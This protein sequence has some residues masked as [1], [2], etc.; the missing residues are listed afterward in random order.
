MSNSLGRNIIKGEIVI[1]RKDR[2][3]ADLMNGDYRFKCSGGFGMQI[4]TMGTALFGVFMVDGEEARIHSHDI[5]KEATEAYQATYKD[6]PEKA[7][8]L[9]QI[10][11][12]QDTIAKHKL[13]IGRLEKQAHQAGLM[14]ETL[15]AWNEFY[16]SVEQHLPQG[17]FWQKYVQGQKLYNMTLKDRREYMRLMHGDIVDNDPN[18]RNIDKPI[19]CP[20]CLGDGKMP[21]GE[22]HHKCFICNGTGE[23]EIK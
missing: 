4:D 13:S 19:D 23:I 12:L 22:D 20:N 7:A 15:R 14:F 6:D 11:D 17:T 16:D 3:L 5:D 8:L 10:A 9:E 21:M 18:Y 1:L 2:Y